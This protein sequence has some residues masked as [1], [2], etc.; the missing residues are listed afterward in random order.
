MKSKQ[1]RPLPS[2]FKSHHC[3]Y[4]VSSGGPGTMEHRPQSHTSDLAIVPFGSYL[5]LVASSSATTQRQAYWLSG[6]RLARTARRAIVGRLTWRAHST[7][8]RKCDYNKTDKTL[9]NHDVFV[10]F[11]LGTL[12]DA[13]WSQIDTEPAM[14]LNHQYNDFVVDPPTYVVKQVC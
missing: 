2:T 9:S 3:R 13:G 8:T 11:R 5:I 4:S 7:S 6:K 14:V 12:W 1:V 10:Y